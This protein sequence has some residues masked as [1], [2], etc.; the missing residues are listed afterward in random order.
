MTTYEQNLNNE[1][2]ARAE[3]MLKERVPLDYILNYLRTNYK[4]S[5]VTYG[6]KSS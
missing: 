5:W 6:N 1:Y 4:D 3:R 2:R